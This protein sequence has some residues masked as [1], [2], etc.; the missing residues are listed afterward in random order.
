MEERIMTTQAKAKE[1]KNFI[2]QLV[3]KGKRA[4]SEPTKRVSLLRELKT[5]LPSEASMKLA[6]EFSKRFESRK[7]GYTRV[8]KLER[9]KSDSA[10]MA[11]IEFV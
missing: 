4:A 5:K 1:L 8:T 10:E 7:S 11:V 3:N 9:R 6:S 2:D